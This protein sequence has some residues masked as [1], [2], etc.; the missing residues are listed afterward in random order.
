VIYLK[1]NL[2]QRAAAIMSGDRAEVCL[3]LILVTGVLGGACSRGADSGLAEKSQGEFVPLF[4][5]KSLEGWDGD[6]RFWRVENGEIIGQ[7]TKAEPAP[8]NTFLIWEGG[9]VA[10]FELKVEFK[11]LSGNS[12][13]QY[14]SFLVD[15]KPW[16]LGG[17]QADLSA[18][19]KWTGAAWGERY[20]K[21]LAA[22]GET[23]VVGEAED[24]RNVVAAVG[25]NAELK[26]FL[27]PNDWNEYHI[28]A[29]GNQCIQMINGVV[30][31][32]FSERPEDRL[33]SGWI[34]LQLH[35]GPPME[36]RF[37]NIELRKLE[38]EDKKQIL[39]LAGKKSHGYAMHEHRAGCHLLARC[40][41]E[42]GEDIV[43]KVVAEGQWPEPWEGYDE[44]DAIVMYCD[45]F[46]NHL[47]KDH[48]DKIQA[49]TDRGIGV[50]CLH[51]GVEVDP[52]ELGPEFL[53]WIGG[54]FEIGWSVNPHWEAHFKSFP[55]HPIAN[56][57]EPFSIFDEWYYHLRFQPGME[58][59]S[60]IL[61]AVPPVESLL[62]RSRD[63][64][65]GS[66]PTVLKKVRE[67]RPQVLAW[68]YDRENG[69]R[70]FGFTGGH[71]HEN[72]GEPEFRQVV[73]NALVWLAGATVPADGMPSRDPSALDLKLNQD[74]P[75]PEDP[76]KAPSRAGM[77][78]RTEA[79][80]DRFRQRLELGTT[81]TNG[82]N[83]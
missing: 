73:L 59:V 68:A 62:T 47:A 12:G 21:M 44:P 75:A 74:Y 36:V 42:S 28:I 76:Q 43:A 83:P 7:S 35:Q 71:Y 5:G 13:I 38:R 56:G 20:K 48:Q 4:N 8:G 66:N 78:M 80:Y 46:R 53:E 63:K 3:G 54:Y 17:Y 45:G 23:T 29:Y 34:G 16:V 37:R 58:G 51:F 81:S 18:N 33:R 31:S 49:L 30:M 55:D 15:D 61:S 50:A 60:P 22:R 9:E 77:Q 82:E 67:G 2:F 70:G 79:L 65:R 27:R 14:R 64:D 6:A 72:W 41:H 24:E 26:S 10:D 1:P 69:G 19:D 39:F 40:L 52:D 57:V 32:E 25:D 11:I